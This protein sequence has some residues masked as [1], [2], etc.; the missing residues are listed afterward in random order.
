MHSEEAAYRNLQ[1]HLNA[2]PVGFP[3]TRSGVEQRI[4][5]SLFT[6]AEARLATAMSYRREPA[7]SICQRA[8]QAGLLDPAVEDGPAMLEAMA[9]KGSIF[10]TDSDPGFRYA[11]LPFAIG[12]FEFQVRH[13]TREFYE[14]GARYFREAFG[15]AYL[16]TPLPQMRVIPVSES[17][18]DT[19][20]IATYDEIRQIIEQAEGKIGVADCICRKG[21]DLAGQACQKTDRRELCLGFRDY[22]DTYQREGWFRP[23]DKNEALEILARSEKEGLVLQ[24][25]NE[26]YPQAVC[27]CC[28]CCCG[29]LNTLNA[30]ANPADFVAANYR[31]RVDAEK[32]TGCG[33]CEARCQMAAI[34]VADGRARV[35]ERRCIG[36][37]VC[38][39]AC[40]AKALSMIPVRKPQVPPET[41]GDL[42]ERLMQEKSRWG[43]VKTALR[44]LRHTRLRDVPALIKG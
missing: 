28:G 5:K 14:D 1:K 40:P 16:S 17:I 41:T 27:A 13:L 42:Y 11:L 10:K 20:H 8:A 25:T 24:A 21:K 34:W 33:V 43:K 30:I 38:V 9:K 35:D 36:C 29:I 15:L 39:P 12:M 2:M 32:C 22:F 18:P 3:A 44:I 31:V 7:D 6:P 4:L 19:Q 37:G 26:Q 23:I